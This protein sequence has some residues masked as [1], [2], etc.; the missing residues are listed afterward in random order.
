MQQ[1]I[2]EADLLQELPVHLQRNIRVALYGDALRR[3]PFFK[4]SGNGF[5]TAC[6]HALELHAYLPGDIMAFKNDV[7]GQLCFLHTGTAQVEVFGHDEMAPS[8]TIL[9]RA[10]P[11]ADYCSDQS[12][13]EP[14]AAHFYGDISFFLRCKLTATVRAMEHCEVLSLPRH[15]FE[16]LC[17]AYPQVAQLSFVAFIEFAAAAYSDLTDIDILDNDRNPLSQPAFHHLRDMLIAK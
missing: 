7:G 9:L 16:E 5:L 17:A 8:S 13:T 1:G 15:K 3:C 11:T 12:A 6:A 2:D 4:E 10:L 14:A